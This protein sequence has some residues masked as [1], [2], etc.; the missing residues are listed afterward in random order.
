MLVLKKQDKEV[1]TS[2]SKGESDQMG[3]FSRSEPFCTVLAQAAWEGPT[4]N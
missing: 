2:G 3:S 4:E 1:F